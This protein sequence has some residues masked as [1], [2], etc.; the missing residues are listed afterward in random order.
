MF[1][2]LVNGKVL[3]FK[4]DFKEPS[5][6][7]PSGWVLEGTGIATIR[8]GALHLREKTDGVGAVLWTEKDWPANFKLSFEVSFSNNKGIGV[9][10]FA[11]RASNGRDALED[12]PARTGAYDEYIRGELDSYS[13]SL[14]RYWPDGGNNPG[15]NLRRNS[16]F[17]LLNQALPDPCLEAGKTYHI[18]ITK[19]GEHLVVAVDGRTVHDATDDGA[20]G[21]VHGKGKVGFRIRGDA[22]CIMRLDSIRIKEL[23]EEDD[24]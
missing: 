23:S 5:T 13:L 20:H 4:E 2:S 3:L 22:S 17:H 7:I 14:H 21:P 6:S 16:G 24:N 8:E 9:F 15:S 12:A 11:A 1:G 10:F 19:R 18:E